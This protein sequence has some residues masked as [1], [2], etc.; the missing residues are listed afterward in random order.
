MNWWIF[1]TVGFNRF[2]NCITDGKLVK[3]NDSH[4]SLVKHEYTIRGTNLEFV[5][6]EYTSQKLYMFYRNIITSIK[7]F[8]S[9]VIFQ[10]RIE[11][12]RFKTFYITDFFDYSSFKSLYSRAFNMTSCFSGFSFLSLFM[13]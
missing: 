3:L 1:L 2:G 5:S 8:F 9:Q 12:I 11:K 13:F 6:F 7:P 10:S 4:K